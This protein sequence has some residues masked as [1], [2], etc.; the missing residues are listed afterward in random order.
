MRVHDSRL[1]YIYGHKQGLRETLLAYLIYTN[2]S[3]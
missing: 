1:W 3:D 2:S